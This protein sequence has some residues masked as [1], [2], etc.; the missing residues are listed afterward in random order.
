MSQYTPL[1]LYRVLC[2]VK[3]GSLECYETVF[4]WQLLCVLC[5]YA[6]CQCLLRPSK[7][8]KTRCRGLVRSTL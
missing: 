7:Y 1:D 6:D 5:P 2:L 3:A 8:S 4:V